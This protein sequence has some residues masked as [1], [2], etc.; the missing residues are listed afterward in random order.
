MLPSG[1]PRGVV[2]FLGGAFVGAAPQLTYSHLLARLSDAGYVVIASPYQLGF[3]YLEVCDSIVGAF[4]P[5][6][7]A[8]VKRYGPLPLIGVGHSAG[9]L[10]HVLISSIF[11]SVPRSANVLISFNNKQASDAIPFF[12]QLVTPVAS[13]LLQLERQPLLAPGIAI[14]RAARNRLKLLADD[15][16]PADSFSESSQASPSSSQPGRNGRPDLAPTAREA[17]R[18][19]DLTAGDLSA[20]ELAGLRDG[21]LNFA[22]ISAQLLP[23]VDQI[24]PILREIDSGAEEFSPTPA[25]TRTAVSQLYRA[26]RTLVLQFDDDS[27]DESPE[28][29]RVLEG[30]RGVRL[31]L[32]SGT[33]VTPLTPRMPE[34]AAELAGLEAGLPLGDAAQRDFADATQLIIDFLREK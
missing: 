22:S 4:E 2:H 19:R 27:I 30:R 26:D 25:Q 11:T 3:D 34:M 24:A 9:A 10:L 13:S 20:S 5:S 6:Y 23:L 29:L 7:A 14:A 8:V 1:Q 32:L 31:Q 21:V 18:V 17:E 12:G 28:L 15:L 16:L 33:H